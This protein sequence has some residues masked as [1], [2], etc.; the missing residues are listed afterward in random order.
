MMSHVVGTSHQH[1]QL[2]FAGQPTHP[3]AVHPVGGKQPMAGNGVAAAPTASGSA[4]NGSRANV[5][6][7]NVPVSQAAAHGA[8]P[9]PPSA[10][11]Q[12]RSSGQRY[13]NGVQP[14]LAHAQAPPAGATNGVSA[15]RAAIAAAPDAGGR[16]PM[17][18]GAAALPVSGSRGL[19]NATTASPHAPATSAPAGTAGVHQ[20]I[21]MPMAPR[22]G[23]GGAMGQHMAAG[24]T[25]MATQRM[26]V[27]P[28]ARV[29]PAVASSLATG[30][31]A[32][33]ARPSASAQQPRA[34]ARARVQRSRAP[35][36]ATSQ[37]PANGAMTPASAAKPHAAAAKAPGVAA[38]KPT[39]AP[40]KP[41]GPPPVLK[42]VDAPEPAH[43]YPFC[44][45]DVYPGHVAPDFRR[46][47]ERGLQAYVDEH[48]LSVDPDV[49]GSELAV[50]V[51]RHFSDSFELPPNDE[52]VMVDFLY[53]LRSAH[54]RATPQHRRGA[55]AGMPASPYSPHASAYGGSGSR[56][57]SR[58]RGPHMDEPGL[59]DMDAPKKRRRRANRPPPIPIG[60]RVCARVK[61]NWI[62]ARTTRWSSRNRAYEVVDEDVED[63]NLDGE[64]RVG[65]YHKVEL[66]YVLRL[67]DPDS[68]K[69]NKGERVLA[70][71]PQTT[72]FYVGDVVTVTRNGM[73][74]VRFDDDEE[75]GRVV[76]KR[77]VPATCVLKIPAE[78]LEDDDDDDDA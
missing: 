71:F 50:T 13:S 9:M 74:G 24:T 17:P 67:T 3:A 66:R 73:V 35:A 77:R 31:G 62:M 20:T 69:F 19:A 41:T 18:V 59:A 60:T 1:Q 25:T 45:R 8:R 16:V 32:V 4:A 76:R 47:S 75:D 23:G 6:H 28:T 12:V 65:S 72:S 55:G 37:A 2:A 10:R 7:T 26:G 49:S 27:T 38:A 48:G 51:A 53:R 57:R 14:N 68:T 39:A 54:R 43:W 34:S 22:A 40:P 46:V 56:G 64:D 21:T 78:L 36:T 5:V 33:S 58:G 11:A 63:E 52:D 70:L 44:R 42:L 61:G 29:S 30:R 15:S